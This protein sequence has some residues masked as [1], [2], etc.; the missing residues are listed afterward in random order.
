MTGVFLFLY[1]ILAATIK[2]QYWHT[3]RSR[4]AL[5][6]ISEA[7]SFLLR[8]GCV[9]VIKAVEDVRAWMHLFRVILNA[10]IEESAA[11]TVALAD[12]FCVDVAL[13]IR[14]T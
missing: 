4:Y 12:F 9:F 1:F 6:P 11:V 10:V 13:L 2:W 7:E 5:S 3:C 8:W 14:F